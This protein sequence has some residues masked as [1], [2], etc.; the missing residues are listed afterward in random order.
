MLN[1]NCTLPEEAYVSNE[2]KAILK[3]K[4]GEGRAMV[5]VSFRVGLTELLTLRIT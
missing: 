3:E 1:P 2:D 4:K 5:T